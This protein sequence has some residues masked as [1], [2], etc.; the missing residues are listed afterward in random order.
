[1]NKWMV[2]E[3]S[4]TCSGSDEFLCLACKG[5]FYHS[6]Y[7]LINGGNV[8]QYAYCPYC[9]IRFEGEHDNSRVYWRTEDFFGTPISNLM[10]REKPKALTED[11]LIGIMARLQGRLDTLRRQA[12]WYREDVARYL[13]ECVLDTFNS[14]G[15]DYVWSCRP[16]WQR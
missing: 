15:S 6:H 5:V 2:S 1:M 4:S 11:P 9:G 8:P 12:E 3:F 16:L 10:M 13:D 14:Y 7:S